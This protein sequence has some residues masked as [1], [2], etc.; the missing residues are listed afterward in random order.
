[1][2]KKD[3]VVKS[4]IL[5]WAWVPLRCCGFIFRKVRS[6]PRKV[7]FFAL[8]FLPCHEYFITAASFHHMKQKNLKKKKIVLDYTTLYNKNSKIFVK[9]RK[10]IWKIILK[11][12]TTFIPFSFSSLLLSLSCHESDGS[13]ARQNT[14]LK[15]DPSTPGRLSTF[16]LICISFFYFLFFNLSS[17]SS[18]LFFLN[19]YF[20]YR[21]SIF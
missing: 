21:V 8:T 2:K 4:G 20:L 18:F 16:N 5:P 9:W 7:S 1:M 11:F 12:K 17:P 13:A 10:I 3:K 6:S 14:S 15:Q 19:F